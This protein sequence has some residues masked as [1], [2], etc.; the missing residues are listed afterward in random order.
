[1]AQWAGARCLWVTWEKS[2]TNLSIPIRRQKVWLLKYF[3]VYLSSVSQIGVNF[4]SNYWFQMHNKIVGVLT[5]ESRNPDFFK[6]HQVLPTSGETFPS[7]FIKP[8]DPVYYKGTLGFCLNNV[9]VLTSLTRCPP[10]LQLCFR[11]ESW[12]LCCWVLT[13]V[14]VNVKPPRSFCTSELQKDIWRQRSASVYTS[15]L[16]R[17]CH[18]AV[19]T[20]CCS[21]NWGRELN[22]RDSDPEAFIKLY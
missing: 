10:L 11:D 12:K 9:R 6:V 5:S 1:M 22:S 4:S 2:K 15:M 13:N 19:R 8:A 17:G 20:S 18:L 7:G 21:C 3:G 16:R 14:F